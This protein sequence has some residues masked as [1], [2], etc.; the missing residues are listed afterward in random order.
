LPSAVSKVE[1]LPT[2]DE[3]RDLRSEKNGKKENIARFDSYLKKTVIT[4]F[5]KSICG[6]F[7]KEIQ[8]DKL[9]NLQGQV[10][11]QRGADTLYLF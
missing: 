8:I 1:V 6:R 10:Q 3:K 4:G 11:G 7:I 9:K 2:V 5:E